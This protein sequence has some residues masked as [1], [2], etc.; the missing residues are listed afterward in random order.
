M[1]V[2]TDLLIQNCCGRLQ[3]HVLKVKIIFK[4]NLII[5][6]NQIKGVHEEHRH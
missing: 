5:Y 6:P 3:T 1:M 4:K 2:V